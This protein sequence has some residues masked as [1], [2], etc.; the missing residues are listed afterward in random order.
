MNAWVP[1]EEH[2]NE[3]LEA[4]YSKRAS[5]DSRRALVE[6]DSNA[7]AGGEI[8][9]LEIEPQAGSSRPTPTSYL[10]SLDECFQVYFF[11]FILPHAECTIHV[12]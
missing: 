10:V 2:A 7:A 9:E 12:S 5:A 6:G 1:Y 3:A 11:F 8:F 4:A